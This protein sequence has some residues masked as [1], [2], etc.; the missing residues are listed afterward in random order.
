MRTSWQTQKGNATYE[1][2]I[3]RKKVNDKQEEIEFDASQ[4]TEQGT[5]FTYFVLCKIMDGARLKD[6]HCRETKNK[7]TPLDHDIPDILECL[8]SHQFPRS[9]RSTSYKT[10]SIWD[11][12]RGNIRLQLGKLNLAEN[13]ELIPK[14]QVVIVHSQSIVSWRS[15]ALSGSGVIKDARDGELFPRVLCHAEGQ[16]PKNIEKSKSIN[17]GR[18]VVFEA[19]EPRWRS[20]NALLH[21]DL[22]IRFYVARWKARREGKLHYL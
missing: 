1:S 11:R 19:A 8:A 4:S 2:E 18:N 3:R 16:Y 15:I 6:G 22:G 13:M 21:C 10:S 12:K 20:V 7:K 17:V 9:K 14:F 5:I